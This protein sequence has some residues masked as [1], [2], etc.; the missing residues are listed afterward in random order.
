M[1][2]NHTALVGTGGQAGALEVNPIVTQRADGALTTT[3]L[4]IAEGTETQHKNVLELIRK[5]I[6]DFEEFGMVAFE[7]RPKPAGQIG[8]GDVTYA[9]LTEEQATLLLA[10]MRNTAIV[11][12]FKKRLVKA[13][14]MMRKALTTRE[15]TPEELMAR[16][17]V[18]ASQVLAAKDERILELEPKA[19]AFD[20]F[21]D[22]DEVIPMGDVA[23]MLGL[24]RNKMMQE[25]R[26]EG[27]L[28]SKG[29]SKNVPYQKYM[30]HFDVR[31]VKYER[32]DGSSG[33]NSVTF[34]QPSGVDF[35]RK[36]L[37]ISNPEM[38]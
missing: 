20:S 17:L 38:N 22:S 31:P 12:E 32:S 36:R 13:F 28:M 25:L 15:D 37:N 8:G 1:Q 16:A 30:Q 14:F 34:V 26:N 5:N 2:D 3:S 21:L 9:I 35:I 10:Y 29:A 7:T 4:A 18:Q 11:K 19:E 27:I 24:G 23:K 33:H 6:A